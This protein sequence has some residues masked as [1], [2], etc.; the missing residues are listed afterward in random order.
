MSPQTYVVPHFVY[1]HCRVE[2]VYVTF[3]ETEYDPTIAKDRGAVD[4]ELHHSRISGRCLW[5][6]HHSQ[7]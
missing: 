4:L 3:E 1:N 6:A 7:V 2:D 5:G